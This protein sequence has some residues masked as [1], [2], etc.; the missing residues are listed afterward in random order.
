MK[1]IYDF[2]ANN[3]DD[4][5]YYLLKA[6]KVVAVEANPELCAVIQDRFKSDISSG[7]LCLE[8]CVL[9]TSVDSDPKVRFYIHRRNHVLSQFPKPEKPQDF[10]EI[11]LPSRSIAS[12]LKQHDDPYY[13][14]LD[15]EHY[16]AEIL[17]E[18]FAL[19]V[20][21]PYIS[22]ESHHPTIMAQLIESGHYQAFKLVDGATVSR[23]YRNVN[24]VSEA[25]NTRYSFPYHSAGPFGEDIVGK[26]LS[27][28]DFL[29]VLGVAG[30][31][32]KD[33]HAS[34]LHSPDNLSARELTML[35][36]KIAM[37]KSI[38]KVKRKIAAI[39]RKLNPQGKVLAGSRKL[40]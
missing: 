12:L 24:I 26:W 31:G 34:R 9:T 2:G 6:D 25:G 11:I 13:I 10:E 21:P 23:R 38:A 5:P 32:W 20:F 30:M 18:L 39:R 27:T 7:K 8:N 16:D 36:A 37:T 15:I 40:Q 28:S 29:A 17:R 33:I 35:L 22:A 19:H 1:I 14:K 3:G 4:I